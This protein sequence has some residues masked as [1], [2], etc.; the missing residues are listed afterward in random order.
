MTTEN[1]DVK[2][3]TLVA[4]ASDAEFG[5]GFDGKPAEKPAAPDKPIP[6]ETPRAEAV[7]AP[8]Y[9]QLTVAELAE[10]K[11]AA[12]ASASHGQQLSKAFGTIGNL[13]KLIN[14]MQSQP[15]RGEK[16]ELKAA[17][18]EMEKD[19]PEL[20]QHI[21]GALEK[22]LSG[23]SA[24]AATEVDDK[25][26]E[27]LVTE[28]AIRREL[29]ILEDAY[30]GWR[31][32]VGATGPNLPAPDPN[33]PFR[34]WLATKGADY[35]KR[36]DNTESAAVI[37]RAIRLFQNE[38]KAPAKPAPTP[39]DTTRADRIR[40][41]VQPRGDGGGASVGDNAEEQFAAGFRS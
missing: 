19:F 37:T 29:D 25:K 9:A 28:R 1:A 40:A 12:S 2:D 6:A 20:T 23:V 32:I 3:E 26:I 13:Q 5:A 36:V 18:A 35:Q 34:K 7:P 39:R 33:N 21:Q 8:E 17:F 27:Q 14:A 31:D 10:L 15:T 4:D 30:P 16:I 24:P 41:A 38:T 22:A 11:A